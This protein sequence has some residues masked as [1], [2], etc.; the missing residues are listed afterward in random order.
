MRCK[1]V[2]GMTAS[3]ISFSISTLYSNQ[4]WNDVIQIYDKRIIKDIWRS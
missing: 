2:I 4:G 3:Q 1:G